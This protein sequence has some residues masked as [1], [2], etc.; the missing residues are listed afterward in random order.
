MKLLSNIKGDIFGGISAAIILL[1]SAI[2][3]GLIAFAPLGVAFS[4]Q[5]VMYGIYGAI[6]CTFFA[7]LFGGSPFVISGPSASLCLVAA[8]F[9][10]MVSE[11]AA[12]PQ[13]VDHHN[14]VL[15]GL[16]ALCTFAGGA[17]QALSGS[18]RLGS[19]IKYIP[20]PI[21]AGFSNGIAVLL[22]IGQI[23]PLLGMSGKIPFGDI[24]RNPDG[25]QPL[26][27][28][29][30]LFTLL[31]MFICQ[32]YARK[33]PATLAGLAVGTAFYYAVAAAA[34]SVALSPVIG[35]IE[36]GFPRPDLLMELF[37]LTGGEAVRALYPQ[38]IAT[39]LVMAVFGSLL[40]LLTSISIDNTLGTRHNSNREL[41]G[42]GIGNMVCGLFGGIPGCAAVPRTLA[43]HRA[44]GR[45]PL[46]GMV[47]G[48]IHLLIAVMLGSLVGKL[49][50]VVFAG[51]AFMTG[52]NILD[53]WMLSLT[54]KSA[55]MFRQEGF[56]SFRRQ[57][58]VLVDL[59]MALLVTGLIIG[60]N[61]V[62]AVGA[63][64]VLASALFIVKMGKSII[65]RRYCADKVRSRRV[66]PERQMEILRNEGWRI[67]VFELEGSLFFGSAE[68][69][70]KEIELSLG[71]ATYCIL[72]MRRVGYTDS[73][74]ANIILQACKSVVR[75]G[76]KMLICNVGKSLHLKQFLNTLDA[77][78]VI[79][80]RDYFPDIDAALEWA[81]Q[82]LLANTAPP[83]ECC[84][85][86][87][88]EQ[89]DIM[90]DFSQ[91]EVEILKRR[92]VRETYAKGELIIPEGDEGRDLYLLCKGSV[93]VGISRSDGEGLVRLV[94]YCP[95]ITF[96]E[97]SLLDGRFRSANVSA[98]E[99]CLLYRLAY[100]DYLSLH[101]ER[102]ELVIKLLSN[103]GKIL[104]RNLRLSNEERMLLEQS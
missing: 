8:S 18:L 94:A 16:V 54:R 104:S 84:E 70:A 26:T 101:R 47:C 81:E 99:D 55:L 17:F 20:Y 49:P 38:I 22:I 27:L 65:R 93:T 32:R 19:A 71:E 43:S 73:T 30:G 28:C 51:I 83:S 2:T 6:F 13:S 48:V 25:I 58:D 90:E 95:G 78:G 74:G 100:K 24:L 21:V 53:R 41:L 86:V 34:G 91:S 45:T 52:V 79:N 69:L 62:F 50:I 88:L 97:M 82:D 10:A 1:P 72:D 4:P 96:G 11:N 92:L 66:R 60:G 15:V 102:P 89:M 3:F 76:Q 68:K 37:S 56:S 98:E 42:Q 33:I 77:T 40:S 14:M 85:E 64:V 87:A 31:V 46:A 35:S 63:G 9:I 39:G 29:V 61:L 5:A 59:A 23:R 103:T 36:G 67:V 80:E 57:G 75:N 7:S 12:I 44:G